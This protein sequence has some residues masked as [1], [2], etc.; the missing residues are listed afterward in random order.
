M[1]KTTATARTGNFSFFWL[2]SV[3]V[4]GALLTGAAGP[5]RAE[6]KV[7][8]SRQEIQLSFA[9]LVKKVAPAVVNIY[10]RKDVQVAD[11][12][13]LY[14]DPFFRRFFGD[15]FFG[16]QRQKVKRS[17]NSLGSGV[18]VD[19]DGMI[20]TNYHVIDGA[21]SITVATSDRRTFQ[22]KLILKDKASDLAVLQVQPGEYRLPYLELRDSDRLEVGDL[23]LAI[24]N[25]FNVGQT[26]TSGIISALARTA[27]GIGDFQFFIQTDAAINPG[28]SGGAL[29][30]MDG[31]LA[32]LNTAIYSKSGGSMGIGFA[33]P[34]NMLRVVIANAKAGRSYVTRPWIGV[35]GQNLSA[36][37]AKTLGLP[38]AMGVLV[39]KVEAGSPAADV[40]L[41]RGDVIL[42][43][44]GHEIKDLAAFRYRLGS[45][46]VG[47][48][49][50][51]YYLRKGEVKKADIKLIAPPEVPPRNETTLQ[52]DNPLSG[53]V[54]VNLSPAMALR[55]RL[56]D[57]AKGI[58]VFKVNNRSP[59]EL[60]GFKPADRILELND[61]RLHQ[62]SDLTKALKESRNSWRL[63]I[64]RGGDIFK[65]AMSR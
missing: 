17:R 29:V 5:V 61:H 44:D 30:T 21:T 49:A 47:G 22:A 53:L 18:I 39:Q 62:V 59:A 42:Q 51:I 13:P 20:I 54:V 35:V 56:P 36:D 9:P 7:P 4:L 50:K 65:V 3:A 24:G 52:G 12:S 16:G 14:D 26:V 23:V 40:D 37:I 27:V 1:D 43:I 38:R 15:S 45:R 8:E 60:Q 25:P 55:M 48:D 6:T 58:A 2:L 33:V 32:G 57:D 64:Q 31:R 41:K 11:R 34:A 10:T 19:P 28:N 46:L 63:V